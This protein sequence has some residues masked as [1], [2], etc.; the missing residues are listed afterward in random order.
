[1][2]YR[3]VYGKQEKKIVSPKKIWL[4]VPAVILFAL[5]LWPAGRNTVRDIILPG[6]PDVTT[7]ALQTLVS[8]LGDGQGFGEAMTAFCKE[9]ITGGQ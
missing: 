4:I 9:I 7:A 2:G 5:L 1:M 3:I 6:D 8:E